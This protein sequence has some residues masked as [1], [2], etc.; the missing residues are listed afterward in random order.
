MTA[1][2]RQRAAAALLDP[3]F[4]DVRRVHSGSRF[5]HFEARDEANGRRVSVKGADRDAVWTAAAV[6]REAEILGRIGTHPHVT[7]FYEQITLAD[8][9]P[10]LVLER[11]SGSLGD[12]TGTYRPSVRNV[13]AM[14]IKLCGALETAHH[15]GVLHTG[16]CPASVQV[17]E[18]GE[19]ALANFDETA[20]VAGGAPD[21]ALHVTSPH[22]APELLE[23]G[24]PSEATDVY[25]MA[26]TLY[27]LLSGR[28]AFPAHRGE[29]QSETSLRILRGVYPALPP[30]VPIELADLISWAMAVDPAERPPTP[31]WLAEELLRFERKQGWTR[32]VKIAVR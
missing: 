21:Y 3:R 2:T 18:W 8:G 23:G 12:L 32:T 26:V 13:V 14:G 31:V 20:P 28:P 9:Q 30:T 1:F 15:A 29:R 24:A 5:L 10:A 11:C 22:T 16:V 4:A 7:T 19:P 17:T 25:G 27:E 6:L